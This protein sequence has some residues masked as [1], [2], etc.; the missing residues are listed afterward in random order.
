MTMRLPTEFSLACPRDESSKEGEPHTVSHESDS[1]LA[2]SLVV[3][4]PHSFLRS[5]LTSNQSGNFTQKTYSGIFTQKTYVL[6]ANVCYGI[7]IMY[8]M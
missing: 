8:L 5:E 6:Y 2:S 7:C 3:L 4:S 1:P